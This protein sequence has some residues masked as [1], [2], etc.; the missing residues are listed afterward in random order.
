MIWWN[1][2]SNSSRFTTS[3][4]TIMTIVLKCSRYGCRR[5]I[6][7]IQTGVRYFRGNG[8]NYWTSLCD[9]FV[10]HTTLHTRS[11]LFRVQGAKRCGYLRRSLYNDK[12]KIE[13][14]KTIVKKSYKS[15]NVSELGR[16]FGLAKPE[17]LRIAGIF[18][19]FNDRIIHF[20]EV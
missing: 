8:H 2:F 6:P 20:I 13:T 17:S 11:A 9:G 19:N 15:K 18:V 3:T 12:T 10:S 16:L 5:P 14:A 1:L 4:T 7:I